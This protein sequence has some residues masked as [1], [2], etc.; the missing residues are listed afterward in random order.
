M[1][2]LPA[3]NSKEIDYL[4]FNAKGIL[5]EAVTQ[6]SRDGGGGGGVLGKQREIIIWKNAAT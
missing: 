4:H 3:R 1:L 2:P 5:P 6:E